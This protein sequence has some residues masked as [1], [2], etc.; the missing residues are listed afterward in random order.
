M[1]GDD[2]EH[3]ACSASTSAPRTNGEAVH[4]PS[5]LANTAVAIGVFSAVGPLLFIIYWNSHWVLPCGFLAWGIVTWTLGIPLSAIVLILGWRRGQPA[6]IRTRAILGL[7]GSIVGLCWLIM[8]VHSQ[9]AQ[10]GPWGLFASWTFV[11][12]WN[13]PPTL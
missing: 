3:G 13:G 4:P 10:Y 9:H 2:T 7:A 8:F 6:F 5:V 1:S 12:T 11:V